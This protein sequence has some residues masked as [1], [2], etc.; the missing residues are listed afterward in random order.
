MQLKIPLCL[1]FKLISPRN[2]TGTQFYFEYNP[3]TGRGYC[4]DCFGPCG[5]FGTK[6]YDSLDECKEMNGVIPHQK[7]EPE[8]YF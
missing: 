1:S 6:V 8:Y 4:V 7:P 2:Y 3:S 5:G